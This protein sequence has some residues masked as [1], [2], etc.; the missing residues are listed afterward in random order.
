MRSRY[1]IITVLLIPLCC[2]G[3]SYSSAR[4]ARDGN[5]L[6]AEEK[7]EDAVKKYTDAMTE[8]PDTPELYFN[9]GDALYKQSQYEEA[10]KLYEKALSSGK[11]SISSAAFYNMGNAKF[12]MG[13]AS[14]DPALL[15]EAIAYYIQSL[16]I[17]PDDKDA[18]YNI[19]IARKVINEFEQRKKSEEP[20]E[21]TPEWPVQ[22]APD[23]EDYEENTAVEKAV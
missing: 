9:V 17:D 4:K 3:W 20:P 1:A 21:Q 6:F 10:I 19:E 2:G 15:K 14:S 23:I 13:E 7:Y 12:K 8:S 16:Q 22:P 5:K 18:K 11:K